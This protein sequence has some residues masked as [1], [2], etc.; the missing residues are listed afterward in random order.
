[1]DYKEEDISY[2]WKAV[3]K[4]I[5]EQFGKQPDINSILFLIGVNELGQGPGDY[6]KET[7]QDLIHIG[8]C[9]VL[10][11]SGY[12]ALEG[13]DQDEWP[14][15]KPLKPLPNMNVSAQETFIKWHIIEYFNL[16]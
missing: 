8:N 15:W 4:H 14:V 2:K 7:K 16:S 12:F 11:L 6:K 10:S 5:Q 13:K 1:M 3:T 9:K